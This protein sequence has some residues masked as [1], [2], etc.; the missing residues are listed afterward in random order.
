MA[1]VVIVFGLFADHQNSQLSDERSRAEVLSEV[2]LIRAKLEGDINGNIQLVRGL[3]SAIAIEPHITQN[4]FAD[5][6]ASLLQSKS[7]IR[8]IAGAPDLVVSLMY[9]VEGNEKAIGLDYRLNAEQRM[10]ALQAR[11]SGDVVMTGPLNLVQGGRAFIARFPVFA[12]GPDGDKAFWGIVSAVIDVDK[13]YSDSGLAEPDLP[14]DVAM[15]AVDSFGRPGARFFGER[16]VTK[17]S[18][19]TTEVAVPSG[20]WLIAATPKGGWSAKSSTRWIFRLAVM[21]V[22]LMVF[23]EIGRAH[24]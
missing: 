7:Q 2:S 9:P 5:L 23:V 14:I 6:A 13:L 10:A 17:D 20:S 3:V 12:T 1:I 4:R 15:T 16:Q 19:V 8:N 11:D 24:V 21:A 18:P 22:G